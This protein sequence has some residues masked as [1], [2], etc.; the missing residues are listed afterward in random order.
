MQMKHIYTF[1]KSRHASYQPS[2]H[3]ASDY[4]HDAAVSIK[5]SAHIQQ[6]NNSE[7]KGASEAVLKTVENGGAVMSGFGSGD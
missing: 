4:L 7:Y 1:P 2:V 5:C 6:T 3:L